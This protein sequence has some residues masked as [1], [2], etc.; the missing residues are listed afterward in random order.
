MK[1]QA[2]RGHGKIIQEIAEVVTQ[3]IETPPST[4]MMAG[5]LLADDGKTAG[6]A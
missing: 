6:M 5:H 3:L 2:S 1:H 4:L